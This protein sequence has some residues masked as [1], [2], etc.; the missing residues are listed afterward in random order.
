VRHG[1]GC[2]WSMR[3]ALLA[4][5]EEEHRFCSTTATLDATGNTTNVSWFGFS[6]TVELVCDQPSSAER[7]MVVA[8]TTTPFACRQ[9]VDSTFSGT[10]TIG[11]EEAVVVDGQPRRAWRLQVRGTFEGQTRGTVT[12]SELID[13]EDGSVLFEQRTT[14]L[15]QRSPL[16]DVAYRQE[17]TFTLISRSP[18]T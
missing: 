1:G 5:H 2:S 3:L 17:A 10:T 7:A 16:G 6:S 4:E 12:V 14:Q 15:T 9:G 18:T 11:A 13:Q 8:L